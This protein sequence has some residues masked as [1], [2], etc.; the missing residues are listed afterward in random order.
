M[1]ASGENRRG[2]VIG[3]KRRGEIMAVEI[4]SAAAWRQLLSAGKLIDN[5]EN[6]SVMAAA[7]A[8]RR[9]NWRRKS[10]ARKSGAAKWRRLRKW[11][12]RKSKAMKGMA[13]A[14]ASAKS[15]GGVMA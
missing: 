13:A 8:Q 1:A 11:L 14:A 7:S 3:M 5:G 9:R 6:R 2:G 12:W 10:G 4:K 15:I